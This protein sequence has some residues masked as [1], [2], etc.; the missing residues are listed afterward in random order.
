MAKHEKKFVDFDKPYETNTIGLRGVIY[1][2]V[3]LFLLVVVTFGLMWFLENV[4]EDGALEA[5]NQNERPMQMSAR[6]NLPPEPRLQGAPGFAVES[7]QGQVNLE[8]A[9]PQSEYRELERQWT[10]LWEE[11]QKDSKTGTVVT[12]PIEEAKEKFLQSNAKA[13]NSEE[14]QNILKESRSIVSDSSAGRTASVVRR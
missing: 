9:A 13:N 5:D 7:E 12:L 2:S 10:K 4:M 11:G 3:G 1:F 6:E 8:L 14:G